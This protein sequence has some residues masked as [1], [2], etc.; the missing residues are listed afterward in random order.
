MITCKVYLYNYNIRYR[1]LNRKHIIIYILLF[2]DP[3]YGILARCTL[4]EAE[5]ETETQ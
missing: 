1:L 2:M 3:I 5:P 4:N